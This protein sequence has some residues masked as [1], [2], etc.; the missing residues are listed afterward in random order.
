[1][2]DDEEVAYLDNPLRGQVTVRR[3]DVELLR[4]FWEAILSE[5][6]GSCRR[7]DS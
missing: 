5:A 4:R 1:M 7:H 2:P 6:Q 3:E